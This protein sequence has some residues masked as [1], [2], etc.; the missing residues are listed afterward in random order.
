M[1]L[2]KDFKGYICVYDPVDYARIAG[3]SVGDFVGFC[4]GAGLLGARCSV[5]N[6]TVTPIVAD[7]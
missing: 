7:E 4:C 6:A 1:A 2:A 3:V 5:D